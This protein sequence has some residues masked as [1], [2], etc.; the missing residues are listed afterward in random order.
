[1]HLFLEYKGLKQHRDIII[2]LNIYIK[3][4][5]V[6]EYLYGIYGYNDNDSQD[7]HMFTCKGNNS[8][9]ILYNMSFLAV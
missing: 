3:G 6:V 9:I 4:L 8:C 7:L 5:A 1:M 2:A